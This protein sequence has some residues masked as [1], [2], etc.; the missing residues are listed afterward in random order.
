VLGFERNVAAH[1]LLAT[2]YR[3][4]ARSW[5]GQAAGRRN[6]H[7]DR[8]RYGSCSRLQIV[9]Q[10]T[11]SSLSVPVETARENAVTGMRNRAAEVGGTY[12]ISAGPSIT[13]GGTVATMTGEIYR[14]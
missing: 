11:V 5:L 12:V 4:P 10:V 8:R 13:M 3:G 9:T 2:D 7:R 14:C 6:A 1:A